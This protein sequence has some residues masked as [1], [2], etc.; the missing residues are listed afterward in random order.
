MSRVHEA[1]LDIA[2]P[3]YRFVADEAL[4]GTGISPA[5]FWSATARIVA[6][7]GPRIAGLLA[8]REGLQRQL[9]AFH[10]AG[11]G[12]PDPVEYERF[13]REIGYLV[14]APED[15]QITTS[16]VDS[17]VATVAGPQLVVPLLNARFATNAANARWGSLYDA[18]YGSD[19]IEE[20]GGRSKG[21]GY[22]PVRG[23]EVIARGR[24]FLDAHFPTQ[25]AR[26]LEANSASSTGDQ[27]NLAAYVVGGHGVSVR[28]PRSGSPRRPFV[29]RPRESPPRCA[30]LVRSGDRAAG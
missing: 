17:E 3:L 2:E 1:G 24:A 14:D 18:L 26:R 19:A 25:L 5:S 8:V 12:Q 10:L 9:D 27:R 29:H 30:G 4:P 15:F 28:R 6:D 20:S 23:A 21:P 11:P 22:N 7:I 13:L 16:G